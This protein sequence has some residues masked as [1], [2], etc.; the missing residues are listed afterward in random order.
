M[1]EVERIFGPVPRHRA[2]VNDPGGLLSVAQDQRIQRVARKIRN[3]F[4][5]V[6]ASYYLGKMPDRAHALAYGT[7]LQNRCRLTPG[8]PKL[9]ENFTVLLFVDPVARQAS[10]TVGY[11]LESILDL[12]TLGEI[13]DRVEPD[14][15]RARWAGAAMSAWRHLLVK[16]DR[17][18]VRLRKEKRV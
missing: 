7:W 5:Q 6:F 10:L 12:D 9:G 11:A 13:L 4:P 3:R 8:E 15:R 1:A 18:W 14:L 2:A 16:L 17:A